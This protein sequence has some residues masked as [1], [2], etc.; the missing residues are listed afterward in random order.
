MH[1]VSTRDYSPRRTWWTFGSACG[2]TAF[3]Y[4]SRRSGGR[5]GACVEGWNCFKTTITILI[6][7]M[8]ILEMLDVP[9]VR[10]E[11]EEAPAHRRRRPPFRRCRDIFACSRSWR[12]TPS[13][14]TVRR[15]YPNW[16]SSYWRWEWADGTMPPT[17]SNRHCRRRRQCRRIANMPLRLPPPPPLV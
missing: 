10:E 2:S 3:R 8:I 14:V 11:E 12:C 9:I 7:I 16:T 5:T 15:R 13:V 6:L 4:R 1:T 17:F